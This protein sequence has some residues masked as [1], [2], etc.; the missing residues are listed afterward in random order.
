M[1]L[2]SYLTTTVERFDGFYLPDFREILAELEHK[3][4]WPMVIAVLFFVLLALLRQPLASLIIKLI[5]RIRREN[6][7]L[8]LK[9]ERVLKK[10]LS[11][12]ILSFGLLI[13]LFIIFGESKYGLYITRIASSIFVIQ[14]F[15]FLYHA[16]GLLIEDIAFI[17]QKRGH[18]P[19]LTAI[20]YMTTAARVAVIVLGV[21]GLLSLWVDN[22]SAIV[23]SIGVGGLIVAL[24]AQDTA[25][26]IFAS[27]AILLD[28]PFSVGDWIV[29]DA[30]EGR[31]E[32]IGLRSTH[33]R[34]DDLTLVSMPNSRVANAAIS[35][36]T[37]RQSRLV[38]FS[39]DFDMNTTVTQLEGLLKEIR[40]ILRTTDGVGDEGQMVYVD[41]L[42]N[43]LMKIMVRFATSNRYSEMLD[44]RERVNIQI[45]AYMESQGIR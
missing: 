16:A 17:T 9:W 30:V 21:L 10:P 37:Q 2:G 32:K 12:A 24:A 7:T 27:I 36:M 42:E 29:I 4:I 25:S 33:I 5:R 38:S 11:R 19:D 1:Q 15:V 35:N 8:I 13:M 20:Y 6:E 40:R 28:K 34:K 44:V 14:L 31:V 3:S 18:K 41:R 26:N 23:A 45:L 43:R 22:V 39:L